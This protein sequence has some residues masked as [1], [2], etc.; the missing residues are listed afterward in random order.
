VNATQGEREVEALPQM[1]IRG[2]SSAFEAW[3]N[4]RLGDCEGNT[5]FVRAADRQS[6]QGPASHQIEQRTNELLPL[7]LFFVRPAG[8]SRWS[9]RVSLG[10]LCVLCGRNQQGSGR[11]PGRRFTAEDAEAAEKF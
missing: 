9:F 2:T 6:P 11:I 5:R 4:A 8:S 10:D 3:P 7:C 1:V